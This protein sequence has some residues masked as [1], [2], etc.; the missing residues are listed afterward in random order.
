MKIGIHNTKGSFSERWITY[1]EA[2]G[3]IYK[4]VDCYSSDIIQQ[5]TDCD[6]LMWHFNHKSP[7]ASK[8]AKQLLLAVQASGKKVF[9]DYNTVWHFDDKVAQKYLLE[10]IE[11]PLAPAYVF[12]SKQEALK[13]ANQ[14][15]Y[16]KVFKLRNGAG[17]DNVRLIKTKNKASR[18]I[19]KAFG[20]GFKQ[21]EA[22]GNLK[23]RFRLFRLGKTTLWDVFKGII[24]IAHTTE[25]AKVTGREIGYVYF[26]DFI[27]GNDYD[28]RV[29]VVG[30]KAFAIKRMVRKNDFRASGSGCILYEKEHFDDETVRLAF[31]VSEKLQAQCMT[32]DFVYLGDK[33]LIVEISYGFAREGYDACTGYWDKDLIWHEGKFN[34]YGWM[35]ELMIIK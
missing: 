23:E 33:P 22:L 11:A 15:S 18:L 26:Q 8:F 9:P 4:L 10:S 20:R 30:D 12:Y 29:I 31:E 17:S 2:N 13:W 3:I 19:N 32:Y 34:P 28:I 35:I 7:K 5:L 21:Y 1:C 24:R 6:A 25:Y 14:T 27:P 16:P